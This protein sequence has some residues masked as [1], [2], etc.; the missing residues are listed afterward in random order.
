ME[1]LLAFII[2]LQKQQ[3]EQ[4]QDLQK[5]LEQQQL[6]QQQLLELYARKSV[7]A[8]SSFSPDSI[9]NSIME[10]S[11]APE[12]GITFAMYYRR[13]KE[14]FKEDC[15]TWSDEVKVRLL[16]H[17][18]ASSECE[19][20]CSFILPKKSC[21]IFFQETIKLLSDIFGDKTS[22]FNTRMECWNLIK[23]R[24]MTLLYMQKQS[25]ECVKVLNLK[26]LPLR[27]FNSSFLYRALQQMKIQKYGQEFFQ[28]LKQR[29]RLKLA[30]C[31]RRVSKYSKPETR[32]KKNSRKGFRKNTDM[33]T[34][35]V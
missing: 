1:D 24:M 21:E 5:Q 13:Y 10:F 6:K 12:E 18:L 17:K 9:L 25:T 29:P 20:H 30:D 26:N 15:K 8:L 35:K 2:Q 11:Y 27:C 22:F 33:L 14:I 4:Q 16:L 28:N 32:H 34:K 3:E 31:C 7:N 23:K 19:Q